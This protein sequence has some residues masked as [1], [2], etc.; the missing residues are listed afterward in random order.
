MIITENITKSYGN[1]KALKG[2]SFKVSNNMKIAFVGESG[3]GKSTIFKLLLGFYPDY[4]G[5]IYLLGKEL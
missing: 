3:G 2:I 1:F 5:E 4:E